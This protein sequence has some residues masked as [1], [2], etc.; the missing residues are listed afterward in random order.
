MRPHASEALQRDDVPGFGD[1]GQIAQR[2][3]PLADLPVEADLNRITLAPLD[4]HRRVDAPQTGR[5]NLID[6]HRAHPIPRR[7]FPRNVELDIRFAEYDVRVHRA[8]VHEVVLLEM[9]RNGDGRLI[10]PLQAVAIDPHG[11]RCLDPR[12]QHHDAPLDRLQRR[13]GSHSR[14]R[15]EGV[16]L[17]PDLPLRHPRPPR[18]ARLEHHVR[19]DHSRRRRIERRVGSP[20]FSQHLGN[21]G[22]LPDQGILGLKH[23]QGLI[24][25]RSRIEARHV[26]PRPLVQR[27]P[28]VGL[29]PREQMLGLHV[30]RNVVQPRPSFS[31]RCSTGRSTVGSP[32]QA[33]SPR[34]ISASG[35]ESINALYRSAVRSRAP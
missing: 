26:K 2:V 34:T 25:T 31:A 27:D 18:R 9:S 32:I 16:D 8:R 11:H 4:R 12:L 5:H 33:P 17:V 30:A 1:D 14:K 35:N 21:F 20:D 10:Q 7:L 22:D 29:E 3:D 24:E 23:L 6:H 13:G 28:V 19:F 15:G